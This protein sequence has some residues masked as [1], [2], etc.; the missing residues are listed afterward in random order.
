MTRERGSIL[1]LRQAQD[2][3]EWNRTEP[4]FFLMLSLSKHGEDTLTALHLAL[5]ALPLKQLSRPQEG[6][7]GAVGMEA[8][9]RNKGMSGIIEPDGQVRMGRL[10]RLHIRWGY[11]S[12]AAAQMQNGRALWGLVQIVDDLAAI[13]A[14]DRR[15]ARALTGGDPGGGPAKAKAHGKDRAVEGIDGGL[16]VGGAFPAPSGRGGIG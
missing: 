2:E 8:I 15:K 4:S 13:E 11:Q 10:D 1:V 3:D 5:T 12:V 9:G 14:T 7:V 6:Q 16:N